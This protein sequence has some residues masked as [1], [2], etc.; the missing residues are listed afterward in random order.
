M[1]EDDHPGPFW[2]L[3][4]N[5]MINLIKGVEEYPENISTG[6]YPRPK[7]PVPFKHDLLSTF[8]TA[9]AENTEQMRR[10]IRDHVPREHQDNINRLI[11]AFGG[12]TAALAMLEYEV[13][14]VKKR[15][16][17]GKAVIMSASDRDRGITWEVAEKHRN[18]TTGELLKAAQLEPLVNKRRAEKGLKGIRDHTISRHI[19]KG[20]L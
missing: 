15:N 6:D 2:D 3:D 13:A 17:A 5:T 9:F 10:A 18:K 19:K 12:S 11:I 20:T 7:D 14:S 8:R 4:F 1:S 16:D